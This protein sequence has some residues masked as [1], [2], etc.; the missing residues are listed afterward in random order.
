[1]ILCIVVMAIALLA[2]AAMLF[3]GKKGKKATRV[4]HGLLHDSSSR[5]QVSKRSTWTS[6]Q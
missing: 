5:S 3:A 1:M 4:I 6:A 2:V